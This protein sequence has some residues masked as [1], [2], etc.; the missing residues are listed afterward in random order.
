MK[1]WLTTCFLLL[2]LVS[3]ANDGVFYARGNT[4]V[5]LKENSIRLKKEILNLTRK[6]EWMQVDIYFEF[7]NPGSD[8]ELLVGFVT[9]PADGDV[10]TE[11]A[12]HP[13]IKEFMVMSG[14]QILPF[15]IARM[16]ETGFKVSSKLAEGYDF[17]YYFTVKFK[18]GLNIIRHSYQYKGG[19]SVEARKDFDYRLTTGTTWANHAID[20]FELNI[21]MGDHNYFS[22]PAA[23]GIQRANW[24]VVGIG[25]I[26][27][28]KFGIPFINEGKPSMKMA[29]LR[30]G[31]LQFRCT[32]FKPTEDLSITEWQLHNEINLWCEPGVKNDF[33]ELMELFWGDA[34]DS[35]LRQMPDARLRLYR[36]LNYARHGYDFKDETLKKAFMK[37]I[38]YL[39]DPSV[40][41]EA[42]PDYYVT[43]EMMQ[44]I[45]TE[46]NRRKAK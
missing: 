17:V 26:S 29:Y 18:K 37:Y 4:L 7:F 27:Q 14:E 34:V 40:K 1:Q 22:L 9:P 13:F 36:N 21:D 35:T 24:E 5:P 44:L 19:G 41:T 32:A 33:S 11:E 28:T 2:A 45:I 3:S 23:F 15:K 42:V 25:R 10:S 12:R 31:K 16:E 39:P 6:D 38:W 8:R 43:Q 46:E 20:D 30:K